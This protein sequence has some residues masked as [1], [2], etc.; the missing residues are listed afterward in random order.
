[1]KYPLAILLIG[2]IIPNVTLGAGFVASS[3]GT[4]YSVAS[5]QVSNS[6]SIN[7][8]TKSSAST[9]G[10]SV[11]KGGSMQTGSASASA[12]SKV[13]TGEGGGTVEISVQTETNGVS[14]KES[15]KKEL[16][17]GE[18][19]KIE[20]STTSKAGGTRVDG[21]LKR[22][23]D[24]EAATASS[25]A[26]AVTITSENITRSRTATKFTLRNLLSDMSSIFRGFISLFIGW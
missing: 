10:N 3:A 2:L 24:P 19:V 5:V 9:G 6:G 7:S 20:I 4:V 8:S 21:Y 13:E 17:P 14:Q 18:S 12:S 16:K 15:Y 22:K 23:F 11:D 26:D 25:S 1:M